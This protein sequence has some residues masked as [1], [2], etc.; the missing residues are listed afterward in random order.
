MTNPSKRK[1]TAFEVSVRDY[2]YEH[3]IRAYRPAPAGIRD[4]GDIHV[5]DWDAILECK[6]TKGLD[7]AGATL[8]AQI[9]AS[10][11]KARYGIAIFKRRQANVSKSYVVLELDQFVDLMQKP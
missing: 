8:E 5:P 1:G 9:E 3:G 6:A 4:E 10:H 7:L 2:L 11:A